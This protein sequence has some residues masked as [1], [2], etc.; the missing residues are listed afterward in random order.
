MFRVP[1]SLDHSTLNNTTREL[2]RL[3]IRTCFRF[4][5]NVQ[6]FGVLPSC[7]R[8]AYTSKYMLFLTRPA[9][10][11]HHTSRVLTTPPS[12]DC[13]VPGFPCP[14]LRYPMV[15]RIRQR[16]TPTAGWR[17]GCIQTRTVGTPTGTSLRL[18]RRP[19]MCYRTQGSGPH[20]I[21]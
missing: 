14:M 18:S 5:S 6:R 17:N 13:C 21:R 7:V 12:H 11:P 4:G 16:R 19:T 8:G 9:G 3:R 15:P 10:Q 20:T 1:T 2:H